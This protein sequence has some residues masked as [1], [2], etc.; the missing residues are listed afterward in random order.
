VF[1]Q[2]EIMA[3]YPGEGGLQVGGGGNTE[4]VGEK[5]G[6]LSA[7]HNKAWREDEE[8]LNSINKMKKEV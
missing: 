7:K 8:F 1:A 2:V 6:D 3:L 5:E 4:G